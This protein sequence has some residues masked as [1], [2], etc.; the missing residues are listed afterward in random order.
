MLA[1]PRQQGTSRFCGRQV[2]ESICGISAPATSPFSALAPGLQCGGCGGTSVCGDLPKHAP[3][4]AETRASA[5]AGMCVQA[6]GERRRKRRHTAAGDCPCYGYT[7]KVGQP[8]FSLEERNVYFEK[9]NMIFSGPNYFRNNI[10]TIVDGQVLK[11]VTEALFQI[12]RLQSLIV[13]R[14]GTGQCGSGNRTVSSVDHTNTSR[15]PQ[16][17]KATDHLLGTGFLHVFIAM[18]TFTSTALTCRYPPTPYKL[19]ADCQENAL[20]HLGTAGHAGFNEPPAFFPSAWYWSCNDWSFSKSA[21]KP[22]PLC[23]PSSLLADA[24]CGQRKEWVTA[25]CP[26]APR[27]TSISWESKS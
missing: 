18:N 17:F 15:A 1:S 22:P 12:Y 8:P 19:E 21:L 2:A 3:G 16:T 10:L 13:G 11:H 24:F 9:F 6:H 27:E 7:S 26:S 25:G 20:C 14:R 5:V 4:L 23:S